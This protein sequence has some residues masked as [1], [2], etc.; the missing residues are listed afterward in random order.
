MLPGQKNTGIMGYSLGGLL[1]CHAA[2]TRHADFGMAGCQS[3]SLWWPFN[4]ATFLECEF[5]F[6]NITLKDE[7]LK[8]NRYMQKLLLDAG[9][10]I[11]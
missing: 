7:N 6:I 9:K 2:W 5:D 8:R 11:A 1:T 10:R 3:P 4:N